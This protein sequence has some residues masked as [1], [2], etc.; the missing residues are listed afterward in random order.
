MRFNPYEISLWNSTRRA[1]FLWCAKI[2]LEGQR[3]VGGAKNT[4]NLSIIETVGRGPQVELTSSPPDVGNCPHAGAFRQFCE[5]AACIVSAIMQL[6]P[7]KCS[8]CLTLL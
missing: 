7:R 5:R 2:F 4:L 1:I 6:L 3:A 8:I